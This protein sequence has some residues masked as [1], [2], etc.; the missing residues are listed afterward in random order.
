MATF[1]VKEDGVFT[2]INDAIAAA[3]A[4]RASSGQSQTIIIYPKSNSGVYG[5]QIDLSVDGILISGIVEGASRVKVAG[6]YKYQNGSSNVNGGINVLNSI[7]C[8]RIVFSGT[9][10]QHLMASDL[11]ISSSD[12]HAIDFTN[13]GYDSSNYSSIRIN[14][15]TFISADVSK[16]ALHMTNGYFYGNNV[17]FAVGTTAVVADVTAGNPH[18]LSGKSGLEISTGSFVG[19]LSFRLAQIVDPAYTNLSLYK[20]SI[21]TEDGVTPLVI[22][23]SRAVLNTINFI[24]VQS[25]QTIDVDLE[26][27]VYYKN[28]L[29]TAG[30]SVVPV[31]NVP[32]NKIAADVS[33]AGGL[34]VNDS[35][36]L[37]SS[38]KGTINGQGVVW[39]ASLNKWETTTTA[40]YGKPT[41]VFEVANLSSWSVGDSVSMT[42]TGLV[43]SD[44][45]SESGSNSIGV[46][47][48]VFVEGIG[49]SGT[50]TVILG[51]DPFVST[52]IHSLPKGTELYLGTNGKLTTY[53]NIPDGK[54]LTLMGKVIETGTGAGSGQIALNIRQV[55]TK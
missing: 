55:G 22:R 15:G 2:T 12:N 44:Y 45:D 37:L 54:W 10:L 13:S 30:T 25:N 18:S 52:D 9:N 35:Q 11:D 24:N 21:R 41:H 16:N 8:Q 7:D 53:S 29:S 48:D 34:V 49:P 20:V 14:Q 27:S 38:L 36:G 28:V 6:Y 19:Q 26:S 46:I 1:I 47:G 51:G 33:G 39:N 17:Q 23:Q 40:V 43:R 31:A 32:R 4:E 3:V 42:D 5:E 50:V